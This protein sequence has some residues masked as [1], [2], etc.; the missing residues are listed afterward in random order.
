VAAL[1]GLSALYLLLKIVQEGGPSIL[2][3]LETIQ[4]LCIDDI[5][6]IAG[7]SAWKHALLNRCR[8][9]KQRMI[10][11]AAPRAHRDPARRLAPPAGLGAHPYPAALR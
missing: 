1:S 3:W 2:E 7:D 4:L 10:V 6:T 11:T 8:E 5:D 9:N